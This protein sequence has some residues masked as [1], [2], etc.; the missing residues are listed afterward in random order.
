MDRE[1][2]FQFINMLLWLFVFLATMANVVFRY[3]EKQDRQARAIEMNMAEFSKT[4]G[5][6]HYTSKELEYIINGKR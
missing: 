2:R 5:T 1:V 6:F 4:D 3:A